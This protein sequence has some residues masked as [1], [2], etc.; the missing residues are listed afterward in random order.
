MTLA[1]ADDKSG[2]R[3]PGLMRAALRLFV[4][5]GIDGT[6][7][8]DIARAANVA[9][10]TLYRHYRSK[11]EMAADL[12]AVNLARF[13]EALRER[14][15]RASGVRAK[16]G[17]YIGAIFEEY[18][19]DPDLFY[20]LIMA[21]HQEL[22]RY[23]KTHRHPGH[24]LEG[25]IADGQREGAL[26]RGDP[27]LLFSVAFGPVHRLCVLRRYGHVKAPLPSF[28]GEVECLVWES[29]KA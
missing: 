13:S 6:T 2:T 10:G 7:I 26:R 18:E 16:L 5:K 8:K 11:E 9:E 24:V 1:I 17:A 15:S 4:K 19:A 14:V 20:Y 22:A 28:A 27:Y 21:E 29:L 3:L 12:F 25:I 23:I